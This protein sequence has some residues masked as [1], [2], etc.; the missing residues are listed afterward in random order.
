MRTRDEHKEQAI[1]EKAIEMIV[2]TGFDGLSMQR[3]AK[4]ANVSPATIY[5]YFKDR[6]DLILQLYLQVNESLMDALLQNFHPEMNFEEGMKVQWLN[7]SHYFVEHPL[8]VR[9]MEQIKH[10]P[11]YEK[12]LPLETTKFRKIMGEFISNAV[13]KK[14]LA[15]LPFEVYWSIAYAPLY[16]LVKYHLQG[17]NHL[18]EPFSLTDKVI[19]QTLDLVL[20]ALKPSS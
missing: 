12:A 7:R 11:F 9:F 10:S 14:E 1:R 8:E 5:I 4:A 15:P 18:N 17:K 20:K 2:T 13:A 3:L 19:Q 6:E 16:Q